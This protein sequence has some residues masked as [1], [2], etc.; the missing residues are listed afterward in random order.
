LQE[1]KQ[2]SSKLFPWIF[3]LSAFFSFAQ[4]RS[5][6]TICVQRITSDLKEKKV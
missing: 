6:T 3:I 2:H 5:V 4:T 1:K